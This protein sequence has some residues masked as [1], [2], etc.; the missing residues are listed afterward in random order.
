MYETVY[1]EQQGG[2]CG[3]TCNV[4]WAEPRDET[5]PADVEAHETNL[6]FNFGW[7][8]HAIAIDGK[9]PPIMRTQIDRKSEEQGKIW[10][11]FILNYY[12]PGN[13]NIVVCVSSVMLACF[14]IR[15]AN[16]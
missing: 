14:E 15:I 4:N 13:N 2:E 6:Q 5:N 10:D 12:S 16:E 9:Y 11:F 3:I 8:L 7:Y 1:K